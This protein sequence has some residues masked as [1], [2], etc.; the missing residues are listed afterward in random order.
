MVSNFL[1]SVQGCELWPPDD[2]EL[3]LGAQHAHLGHGGVGGAP[4]ED[5][6]RDGVG[7]APVLDGPDVGAQDGL[8]LVLQVFEG[9]VMISLPLLPSCAAE[10]HICLHH[11]LLVGLGLSHSGLVDDVPVEAVAL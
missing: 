11:L 7:G 6:P 10:S 3:L 4:V 8:P 2:V 5:P 9:F 1:T